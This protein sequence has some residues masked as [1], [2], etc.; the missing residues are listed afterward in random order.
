VH[1]ALAVRIVERTAALE[2]DLDRVLDIEL[3]PGRG[4][5]SQIAA[6][7]VLDCDIAAALFLQRGFQDR[8]DVRVRD[9][10]CERRFVQELNAMGLVD[11]LR[12]DD[13]GTEY[14]QRDLIAA[15]RVER[16]VDRSGSAPAEHPPEREFSELPG[17]PP[18]IP[19]A[20]SLPEPRVRDNRAFRCS[21]SRFPTASRSCSIS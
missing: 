17:H 12:P 19:C 7:H 18:N 14:L 3:T 13:L 16:E 11:V 20:G 21:G 1:D 9:P 2:R 5:L 10:A 4:E 6:R 8:R 15:E